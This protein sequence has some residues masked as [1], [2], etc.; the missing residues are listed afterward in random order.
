MNRPS[1]TLLI[2][3]TMLFPSENSDRS[4]VK[5]APAAASEA[6]KIIEQSGIKGGLIVHLGLSDGKLTAA[7]RANSR[8]QVHGID[9][10][11]Q[12]V[13]TARS[14]LQK[15]GV[16]G[17]VS[18][19]LLTGQRLPY[20]ENLVNLIV[21]EDRSDISNA[22]ILRALT[23]DGVAF[24]RDEST[25]TTGHTFCTAR[26]TTPSRRTRSSDRHGICNGSAALAGRGTTTAWRA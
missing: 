18:V 22:E 26:A 20:I 24:I 19:G 14:A 17:E 1:I 6:A 8:Y 11:I 4:R 9:R 2:L 23:P 25:S 12:K 16:Y 21:V 13:E 7:L 5:A 15:M 10:D 3:L